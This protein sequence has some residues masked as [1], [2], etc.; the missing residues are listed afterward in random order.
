MTN[1]AVQTVE[2]RTVFGQAASVPNTLVERSVSFALLQRL[3]EKSE[4][5]ERAASRLELRG[6]IDAAK[7]LRRA[8]GRLRTLTRPANALEDAV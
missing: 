2:K 5:Y 7:V 4:N 8:A 6:E 1:S 3:S